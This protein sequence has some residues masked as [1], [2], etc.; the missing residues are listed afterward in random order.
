MA[1]TDGSDTDR[2][3]HTRYEF[4]ELTGDGLR[5]FPLVGPVRE[6]LRDDQIQPPSDP[7]SQV[8]ILSA[9]PCQPDRITSRSSI[10]SV[11]LR[12]Q[13]IR[14][15]GFVRQRMQVGFSQRAPA[16]P[17]APPPGRE[18]FRYCYQ[19]QRRAHVLSTTGRDVVGGVQPSRSSVLGRSALPTWQ[20]PGQVTIHAAALCRSALMDV[21]LWDDAERSQ[22]LGPV[23]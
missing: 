5:R 2:C 17:P 9:R 11:G 7:G 12:T 20:W 10:A 4:G 1:T 18:E 15:P 13:R 6:S 21:S 8:Q 3:H 19:A 16:P 22:V 23:A 14:Q